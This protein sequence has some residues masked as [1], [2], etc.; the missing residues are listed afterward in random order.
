MAMMMDCALGSI[1][2]PADIFGNIN[3][4]EYVRCSR[5]GYGGCDVRVAGCGCTL[6]TVRIHVFLDVPMAVGGVTA[7]AA[8]MPLTLIVFLMT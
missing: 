1:I 2:T 5:C 6:H 4:D 8:W 3:G 7:N